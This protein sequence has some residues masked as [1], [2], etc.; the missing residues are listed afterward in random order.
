MG[1]HLLALPLTVCVMS[2]KLLK[3]AEA[4]TYMVTR[5]GLGLQGSIRHKPCLEGVYYPIHTTLP[6]SITNQ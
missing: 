2:G 3:L 6:Q 4:L 1:A 5:S